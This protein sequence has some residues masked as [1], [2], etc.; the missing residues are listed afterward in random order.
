M[1]SYQ[2]SRSGLLLLSLGLGAC[3]GQCGSA[4]SSSGGPSVA[5]VAAPAL[6]PS[7]VPPAPYRIMWHEVFETDVDAAAAFYANVAG[8]TTKK[9]SPDHVTFIGK[10]G[11]VADVQRITEP[12]KAAGVR[13]Y[14]GTIVQVADVDA[15]TEL[16]RSHGARV[17]F[18]PLDAAGT[19]VAS[20]V[21]G[22][23]AVLTVARWTP[24]LPPR[25]RR[26][27]GEFRWDELVTPDA[28]GTAAL[29]RDLFSW[30]QLSEA[31][32][33]AAGKYFVLGRDGIPVAGLF[34][35]PGLEGSGWMSYVHVQD[36][37]AAIGRA[38]R[39]GATL[40][41]GPMAAGE[42]HLA[43]LRDPEGALFGLREAPPDAR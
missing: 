13:P 24:P 8:W 36:L 11:P 20:F 7:P 43:Q 27:P 18:G 22:D 14:W 39:A 1:E 33:G 10:A 6:A 34:T 30:T 9:E 40:T 35:D 26:I 2:S 23:G 3:G 17:V 25:D 5:A 37:D 29:L 21:D 16:A 41:L 31:P 19:R 32:S 38:T 15:T 4:S 42:E 28:P 12:L